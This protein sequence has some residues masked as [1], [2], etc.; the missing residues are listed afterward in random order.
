MF[1]ESHLWPFDCRKYLAIVRKQD[2]H[3]RISFIEQIL[4][5]NAPFFVSICCCINRI[6]LVAVDTASCWFQRKCGT[7][8]SC[9]AP[10]F[11]N[12]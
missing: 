3:I 5:A 11:L 8:T 2:A 10:C 7:G 4:D 1:V 9:L 6:L 12:T